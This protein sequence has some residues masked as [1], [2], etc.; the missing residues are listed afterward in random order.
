MSFLNKPV[1][2]IR[3]KVEWFDINVN[4]DLCVYFD[5]GPSED[6]WQ[7]YYDNY[8]NKAHVKPIL[9]QLVPVRHQH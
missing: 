9:Y 8:H 6:A 4:D 1:D 5:I 3:Y 2:K 7:Y